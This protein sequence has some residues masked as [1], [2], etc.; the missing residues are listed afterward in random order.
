[1]VK[2]GGEGALVIWDTVLY[3]QGLG[4]YAKFADLNDIIAKTEATNSRC[5]IPPQEVLIKQLQNKLE[6]H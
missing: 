2:S 3:M 5:S 4:F 6:V 1:M